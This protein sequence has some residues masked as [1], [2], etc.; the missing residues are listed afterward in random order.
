RK[1]SLSLSRRGERNKVMGLELYPV[2]IK[3]ANKMTHTTLTLLVSACFLGCSTNQSETSGLTRNSTEA[4]TDTHPG[5]GFHLIEDFEKHRN[6]FESD[7]FDLYEHST[8]GGELI[9]FHTKDKDYRV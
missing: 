8:D 4:S 2:R 1:V 9:S 5:N 3:R 7:T 6:T